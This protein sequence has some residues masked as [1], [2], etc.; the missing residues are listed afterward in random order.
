MLCCT[1]LLSI[2]IK[3]HEPM[4][5]VEFFNFV[6]ISEEFTINK[7]IFANYSRFAG[8]IFDVMGTASD[9]IFTFQ[10]LIQ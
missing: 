7:L 2:L 10:I 4:W 3:T 1:K 8:G 6:I 5:W 9:G